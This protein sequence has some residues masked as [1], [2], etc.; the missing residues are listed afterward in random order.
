MPSVLISICQST[1]DYTELARRTQ[2]TVGDLTLALIG[3]GINFDEIQV[4]W[5]IPSSLHWMLKEK[6]LSGLCNASKK[7]RHRI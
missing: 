7:C 5:Y 1:R 3:N 2:P 4:S 6:T